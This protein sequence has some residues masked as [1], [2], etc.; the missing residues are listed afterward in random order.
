M[1]HKRCARLVIGWFPK[2]PALRATRD[3]A[4]LMG[5][6]DMTVRTRVTP[7][8]PQEYVTERRSPWMK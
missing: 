2:E 6:A 1:S 8:A 7:V 4:V 3:G 5:D